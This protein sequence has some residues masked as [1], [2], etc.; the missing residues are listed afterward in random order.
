MPR[1]LVG[2]S[3]KKLSNRDH[4]ILDLFSKSWKSEDDFLA[5][6]TA[7]TRM[8]K[9]K[10][11]SRSRLPRK[12]QDEYPRRTQ[13]TE[14]A[15][16]HRSSNHAK[17]QEK[18]TIN[19]DSTSSD[20]SSPSFE[21][22]PSKLHQNDSVSDCASRKTRSQIEDKAIVTR[23]KMTTRA[24]TKP[25]Q[26]Y[27]SPRRTAE[28]Q[29]VRGLSPL[30]EKKDNERLEQ[31][32][33]PVVPKRFSQAVESSS[34][35][36]C[37][38]NQDLSDGEDDELYVPN[39]SSLEAKTFTVEEFMINQ[40]RSVSDLLLVE[41]LSHEQSVVH[42]EVALD[43]EEDLKV[44]ADSDGST[45]AEKHGEEED[46]TLRDEEIA[47]AKA[48]FESS[49]PAPIKTMKEEGVASKVIRSPRNSALREVDEFPEGSGLRPS[50]SPR[51]RD[52]GDSVPF[53]PISPGREEGVEVPYRIVEI[54]SLA[55]RRTGESQVESN[56]MQRNV[57]KEIPNIS[58]QRSY[59]KFNATSWED[60]SRKRAS[61]DKDD[62]GPALREASRSDVSAR[63]RQTERNRSGLPPLSVKGNQDG[64]AIRLAESIAVKVSKDSKQDKSGLPPLSAK[65]ND[66]GKA[67]SLSPRKRT[68]IFCRLPSTSGNESFREEEQSLFS[69]AET[70]QTP[71]RKN[72]WRSPNPNT[73]QRKTG[74]MDAVEIQTKVSKDKTIRRK[75]SSESSSHGAKF[76]DTAKHDETSEDG[77]ASKSSSKTS[78]TRKTLYKSLSHTDSHSGSSATEKKSIESITRYSPRRRKQRKA[79]KQGVGDAM[80][81]QSKE[82]SLKI[83]EPSPKDKSGQTMVWTKARNYAQTKTRDWQEPPRQVLKETPGAT[84]QNW[85]AYAK[86]AIDKADFRTLVVEKSSSTTNDS[87][88]GSEDHV[89]GERINAQDE[90]L[91]DFSQVEIDHDRDVNTESGSSMLAS[92][93]EYEPEIDHLGETMLDDD[94][95]DIEDI[96]S[97][98]SLE[99]LLNCA[100]WPG[101]YEENDVFNMG[102]LGAAVKETAQGWKTK[103]PF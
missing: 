12:T 13:R 60:D 39:P 72:F 42:S 8:P 16:V 55:R 2:S 62:Y 17:A 47:P 88:E 18:R 4:D 86:E 33:P 96:R 91:V 11:S 97:A 23:V 6:S 3:R 10:S 92:F 63:S 21:E 76:L 37:S 64:K 68:P 58:E 81:M 82:S 98:T 14:K 34:Y 35:S 102:V 50:H 100:M 1:H 69:E 45:E 53:P 85:L 77:N 32:A 36:T 80:E 78:S 93:S 20:S 94:S 43:R 56:D 89:L 103:N 95:S 70:L 65:G 41:S 79:E 49:N 54:S 9:L 52:K 71:R 25:K 22:S 73:S 15:P 66:D 5:Y 38:T 61:C 90:V 87:S 31:S 101:I 57:T 26:H 99:V 30:D 75:I 46:V 48:S 27:S 51:A 83:Y 29:S 59:L 7:R 44:S 67:T 74:T 84:T 28:S 19:L 24:S 40:K